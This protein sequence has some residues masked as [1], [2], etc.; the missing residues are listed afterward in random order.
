MGCKKKGQAATEAISVYGWVIL[1]VIVAAG[2]FFVYYSSNRSSFT[3]EK[4]I[5]GQGLACEEFLV[6]EGSITLRIRNNMDWDLTDVRFTYSDCGI[7]SGSKSLD[8]GKTKE[9]T[10]SECNFIDGELFESS[11]LAINYTFSGNTV[12]HMKYFGLTAVVEGGNS[13]S[14]GDDYNVDGGTIVLIK[15][16]DG[17]G[18]AIKIESNENIADGI[19]IGNIRA[20]ALY[21]F[22]EGRDSFTVDEITGTPANLGTGTCPGPGGCPS[23]NPSGIYGRSLLFSAND[24]SYVDL[25]NND[26]F[27]EPVTVRSGEFWFYV[28]D[29]NSPTPQIIYE[30]G[31]FNDGL[32]VVVYSGNVYINAWYNIINISKIF[33]ATNSNEWHHVVYVF[34]SL[35]GE[36][37][38]YYDGELV[39]NVPLSFSVPQH[40]NGG[41]FGAMLDETSQI[42]LQ[43]G[44]Y[45]DGLID[46]PVFYD[47]ALTAE[48]VKYHFNSRKGKEFTAWVN[49]KTGSAIQFDNSVY[50]D[51]GNNPIFQDPIDGITWEGWIYLYPSD[52]GGY[53][54]SKGANNYL[55]ID[56]PGVISA[57][58][59]MKSPAAPSTLSFNTNLAVKEWHH[60]AVEYNE[61]NGKVML[62]LDGELKKTSLGTP[63]TNLDFTNS[64]ILIGRDTGTNYFN[65]IIDEVRI[66]NYARY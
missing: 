33:I 39:D 11:N 29:A 56:S 53:I 1:I 63:N 35:S 30:E 59:K 32:S 40:N 9:F 19:V 25:S 12:V 38:M 41:A 34:D 36:F 61:S 16:D 31:G 7:E 43:N 13:Q 42:P 6:D 27:H 15:F 3:D 47:Y 17:D 65:G 52:Y 8:S 18:N 46:E 10:V 62:F 45:L 23:W 4:C 51:I 48:E 26:F 54:F 55:K 14:F 50:V 64:N 49:G 60:I 20:S 24:Q 57:S 66:S 58:F 28:S 22:D 21:Y 5:L 44:Y 37:K 2:A